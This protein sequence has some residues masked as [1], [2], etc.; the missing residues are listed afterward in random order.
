M[1]F[2]SFAETLAEAAQAAKLPFETAIANLTTC[3]LACKAT[4][5]EDVLR[6]PVLGKHSVHG[7]ASRLHQAE[8]TPI[9]S[10]AAPSLVRASIPAAAGGPRRPLT[11]P[12]QSP[13]SPRAPI[14]ARGGGPHSP[15]ARSISAV[16]ISSGRPRLEVRRFKG[17]WVDWKDV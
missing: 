1:A 5:L 9:A 13:S 2:E 6:L 12:N 3:L 16:N 15:S 14:A 11:S 17:L 10:A 8:A 7:T 4:T